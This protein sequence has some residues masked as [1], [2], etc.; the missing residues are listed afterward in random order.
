MIPLTL[1]LPVRRREEDERFADP[2]FVAEAAAAAE[3][4]GF[5]GLTAPDHVVSPRAWAAAGGGELWYDPFVLLAFV[6]GRTSRLRLLTHTIV[7]PCRGPFPVAKALAS[8]DRLSGGRAVLGCGS[9]YLREEFEILGVPFDERGPRTDEALDAIVA[10][11]TSEDVRFEGRFYR[12]IDA[13][14][15]P[16]PLQRPRPPIWIG[17]NSMR[18]V[19]R[20]VERGDVWTPFDAA[21]ARVADGLAR[22]EA[23][24]RRIEVAAPLGR[25]SKDPPPGGRGRSGDAVAASAAEHL[26]AGASYLKC[27]FG[28]RTPGEWLANL[29]WFGRAVAPGLA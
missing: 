25:I 26:A 15:G 28:G 29:E 4:L 2:S 8:L 22:A 17:G 14:M 23:L 20:T 11:W 10:C 12:M 1:G 16:R 24:G 13:S 18:A 9:G 21:P 19:R 6:A 7:L 5:W 3:E 27:A